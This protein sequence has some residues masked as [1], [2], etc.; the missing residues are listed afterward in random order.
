MSCRGGAGLGD[1]GAVTDPSLHAC[2]EEVTDGERLHEVLGTHH[3]VV[4]DGWD[5]FETPFEVT[6]QSFIA[7][8]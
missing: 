6:G 1:V 2:A 5:H 3:T 4:V 7:G 8:D